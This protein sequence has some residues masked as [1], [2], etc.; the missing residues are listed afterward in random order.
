MGNKA[1]DG[2]RFFALIVLPAIS[3]LYFGFGQIWHLPFVTEVVGSIA[4]L[5]TVLGTAL[6]KVSKDYFKRA[7]IA[8]VI[9]GSDRDG[10][11]EI[12]RVEQTS[13]T[14]IIF[15]EGNPVLMKVRRERE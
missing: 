13:T 5:D 15:E 4:I 11:A 7:T 12:R 1:Y 8:D 14:P 9:V 2:L 3:A 6:N 10:N